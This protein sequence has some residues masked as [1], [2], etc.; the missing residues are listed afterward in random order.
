VSYGIP[1]E[2]VALLIAADTIPDLAGTMTNVTADLVVG[3]IVARQGVADLMPKAHHPP[4]RELSRPL[5]LCLVVC[6]VL[7]VETGVSTGRFV[8]GK[9]SGGGRGGIESGKRLPGQRRM[10]RVLGDLSARARGLAPRRDSTAQRDERSLTGKP[11]MLTIGLSAHL[12]VYL[13]PDSA[14]RVTTPPC[15]IDCGT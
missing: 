4:M 13:Y 5:V 2:G 6:R 15:S 8:V 3:T 12:E 7:E 1:A 9:R 11:V 10:G 14:A